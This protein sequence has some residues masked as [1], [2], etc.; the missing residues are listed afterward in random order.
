MTPINNWKPLSSVRTTSN[1]SACKQSFSIY[2]QNAKLLG[3]C[4]KNHTTVN[5]KPVNFIR[6]WRWVEDRGSVV[7][8]ARHYGK[9][10]KSTHDQ[11]IHLS[12]GVAHENQSL[13]IIASSNGE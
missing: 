12:Q 2:I 7:P 1:R 10:A 9:R 4:G 3:F 8:N 11:D 5:T 13:N 6:H